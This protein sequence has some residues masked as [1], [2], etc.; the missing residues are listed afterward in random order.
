MTFQPP[1]ERRRALTSNKRFAQ[2]TEAFLPSNNRPRSDQAQCLGSLASQINVRS[3]SA[4][5]WC[6]EEAAWGFVAK[7][8][9][10]C[11]LSTEGHRER[12]LLGEPSACIKFTSPVTM[13]T[14]AP[15]LQQLRCW[16]RIVRS[17]VRSLKA[18]W[19]DAITRTC[20]CRV[21]VCLWVNESQ[22]DGPLLG[23]WQATDYLCHD[24]ELQLEFDG[25]KKNNKTF[26]DQKISL[27]LTLP[28]CGQILK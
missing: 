20:W 14:A 24:K 21:M 2:H 13:P 5:M 28:P 15:S 25:L 11:W 10:K 12:G 1:R 22:T 3:H 7:P 26:I 23:Y 27:S 19:H 4:T 6:H 17:W 9:S 8:T 18:V 16:C